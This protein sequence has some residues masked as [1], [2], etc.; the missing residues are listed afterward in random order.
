MLALISSAV[1]IRLLP[2]VGVLTV[3]SAALLTGSVPA[4]AQLAPAPAP[5]PAPPPPTAPPPPKEPVIP[6]SGPEAERCLDPAYRCPDLYMAR[7]YQVTAGRTTSGRRL[8]YSANAIYNRGPGP[9]SIRGTRRSRTTMFVAQ[10]IETRRTVVEVERPGA[11]I[12]FKP[13]PGQGAYWKFQD[14]ARMELWTAGE[15]PRLVRS[16]PKLVYC[17]RDLRRTHPG[18]GSPRRFVYPA[19]SRDSSERSVVLGTS[20][21][22]ADIYPSTYHEQHIDVSGLRGCFRLWHVADPLNHLIETDETNNASFTQVRLPF[23]RGTA[24]KC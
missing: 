11:R 12:V 24:G 4:S 10:R 15:T 7:P 16:G 14:A 23:K 9:A 13:I 17:L 21:G 19:C 1:T 6:P 5:A 8:L 22:W 20:K 3:G 18:T 2:L